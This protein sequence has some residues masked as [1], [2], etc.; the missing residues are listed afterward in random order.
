MS[1]AES[2]DKHIVKN[3]E[4]KDTPLAENVSSSSPS[5]LAS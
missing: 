3:S 2:G 5:S 4:I 1:D